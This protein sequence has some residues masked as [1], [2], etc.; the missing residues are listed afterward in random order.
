MIPL[1]YGTTRAA[2]NLIDYDD[3]T[4]TP[5]SSGVKGKGGGGGKSG[6]QQYN[7]SA[8]VILGV[9]Q[10]PVAAF[11]TVWWNK[12][13]G[14]LSGMPGAVYDQPRRR[15]LRRPIRSGSPITRQRR[16][17]IPALPMSR[18]ITISSA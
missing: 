10:G 11:G 5:A 2:P 6:S 8:S 4:A 17:A 13:T 9:C 18:S 16:S 1:V 14:P 15:R 3:F 12:N 7:Y